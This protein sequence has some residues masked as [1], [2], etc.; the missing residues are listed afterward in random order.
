MQIAAEGPEG[1]DRPVVPV[2]GDRNH[3]G[4]R[5]DIDA[6]GIRVDGG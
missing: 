3:M 2:A 4:G 5:T 6:R 1:A